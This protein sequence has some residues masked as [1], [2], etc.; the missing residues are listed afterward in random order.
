MFWVLQPLL[1]AWFFQEVYTPPEIESAPAPA[2]PAQTVEGGTV[3]FEAQVNRQGSIEDLRLLLDR[4]PFT[5]SARQ[6]VSQWR[7]VPARKEAA[8]D[9]KVGVFVL[10]RQRALF[11]TGPAK[12]QY[13]WLLPEDERAAFPTTITYPRYPANTVAEGVVILQLHIDPRGA[14]GTIKV[15]RDVPPLTA[16]AQA[17]VEEWTFSPARSEGQTVPGTAVVAI[18]FVRPFVQPSSQGS[19]NPAAEEQGAPPLK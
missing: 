15:I 14:I 13:D 3:A 9:S 18:S 4:P 8:I 10:F 19:K 12:Q 1:A 5:E 2:H 16:A 7:F 17:A 6:S 11:T